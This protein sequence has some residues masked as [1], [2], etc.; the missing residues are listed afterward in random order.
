MDNDNSRPIT[1]LLQ[2]AAD[3][4][5]T[6]REKLLELVYDELRAIAHKR[7][8]REGPG[9][10][11]A[12]ELVH[13]AFLRVMGNDTPE[14]DHRRH[15]FSAAARAMRRILID[16]HRKRSA[17]KRGG[18]QRDRTFE[19]VSTAVLSETGHAMALDVMA[20]D[21]A[22]DEFAAVDPRAHRVVELKFFIG[23]EADEIGE[24]LEMSARSVRRDWLAAKAWL[25]CR[26]DGGEAAGP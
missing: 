8:V 9:G 7:V 18:D 6:A 10:L 20:L 25:W 16:E 1:L 11:Q 4:D 19:S 26:I 22:L 15:F 23:L 21:E 17:E 2:G 24:I 14:F 13:E 5:T 3:G 12:T